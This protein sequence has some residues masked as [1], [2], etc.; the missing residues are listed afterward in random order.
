MSK[1]LILGNWQPPYVGG[2]IVQNMATLVQACKDG[3]SADLTAQFLFSHMLTT[4]EWE[5]AKVWWSPI[6][7][8]EF[9]DESMIP[10]G[11]AVSLRSRWKFQQDFIMWC[12]KNIP[13][14]ALSTFW[15]RHHIIDKT[16]E[17]G[18]SLVEAVKIVAGLKCWNPPVIIQDVFVYDEYHEVIG[19]KPE[20]ARRLLPATATETLDEIEELPAEERLERVKA[21]ACNKMRA[22]AVAIESGEHVRQINQELK[23]QIYRAPTIKIIPSQEATYAYEINVTRYDDDD[24]GYGD[25]D[26]S[27]YY[28]RIVSEEGEVLDDFPDDVVQWWRKKLGVR[29]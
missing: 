25:G 21:A 18:L 2:G 9:V 7:N 8:E 15:R 16:T 27:T 5:D 12:G 17:L 20:L 10:D 28:L 23:R 26:E 19:Y 6:T 1:D 29:L 13:G 24:N 14:F 22:M 4:G 11:L 3:Q